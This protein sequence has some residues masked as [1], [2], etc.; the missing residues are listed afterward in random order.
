MRRT[1]DNDVEK[2]TAGELLCKRCRRDKD[3]SWLDSNHDLV[4][5]MMTDRDMEPLIRKMTDS[6]KTPKS[7]KLK[8]E[9]DNCDCFD[10]DMVTIVK[11]MGGLRTIFD[12]LCGEKVY[13]DAVQKQRIR[14]ILRL[15]GEPQKWRRRTQCLKMGHID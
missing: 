4:Q 2:G 11:A 1:V 7:P 5:R 6:R 3:E 8:L 10:G 9:E 14:N 13:L 12:L 15:Q